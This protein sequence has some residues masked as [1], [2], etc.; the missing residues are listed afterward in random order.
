MGETLLSLIL[1]GAIL[2]ASAVIT[3]WF[4]RALYNRCGACGTLN[5]RRRAQCRACGQPLEH[6]HR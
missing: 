2:A 4:T 6:A 3:H 1:L 5:A